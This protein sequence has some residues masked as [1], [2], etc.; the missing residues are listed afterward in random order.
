MADVEVIVKYS[1]DLKEVEQALSAKTEYL[2]DDYAIMTLP[3]N[4]AIKLT[5]YIQIEYVE[6]P[7]QLNS[8]SNTVITQ[9][10]NLPASSQTALS[11]SCITSVQGGTRFNLTGKYILV[12][13]LDSGIDYTHPDFLGSNGKTR[14]AY[15]WDQT[16]KPPENGTG[17]PPPGFLYG[18]EYNADQINLAIETLKEGGNPYSI[19]NER[20]ELGHGTGVAGVAAGLV[21]V[22]PEATLLVVKLGERESE[23]NP[24][25]TQIM[26]GVKYS[27]DKA[28]ELGLPLVINLSYGTNDGG[29]DGKSLFETYINEQCQKWRTSFVVATGNEGTAGHHYSGTVATN[30]RVDVE[31][32]TQK[33]I[34][35]F[36]MTLWKSFIDSFGLE[37]I[38]PSGI[39]T[40]RINQFESIRTYTLEDARIFVYY[41]EATHYN[42][43]QEVFF[44]FMPRDSNIPG[45]T[46]GIA[47]GVWNLRITGE[48]IT[49]GRFDIWLPIS[50]LVSP[51]TAF[52]KPES[53]TTLTIPSTAENVIS[54]GGYNSVIGNISSF[55]GQGFTRNGVFVKPN[56]VAPAENIIAPKPGGGYDSYTGTSIAAPF[57]SGSAALLMQWGIVYS[58]DPY[59][60]GQRLKAFLQNG[61]I[62]TQGTIYP[63]PQSGY[64]KLCLKS[65]LDYLNLY[66]NKSTVAGSFGLQPLDAQRTAITSDEVSRPSLNEY[67][68]EYGRAIPMGLMDL[69]SLES[70]GILYL[71]ETP[72][73]QLRGKG[74]ILGFA[75][76]G[77]DYTQPE[78]IYEDGTSKILFLWDQSTDTVYTNEDISRA[79]ASDDPYE[80]VPSRDTSGHGTFLASVAGARK[81]KQLVGAAPD[82]DMIVVKLK[83]ASKEL[84][85]NFV[86][87]PS[88]EDVFDSRDLCAAVKFMYDQATALGKP[89][90]ICIGIGTSFT[91]HDGEADFEKFIAGISQQ[92][93]VIISVA[94]GNEGNAKHHHKSRILKSGLSAKI[95]LRVGEREYGFT[96]LLCH[97]RTDH[98]SVMIVAPSGERVNR[99]SPLDSDFTGNFLFQKGELTIDYDDTYI[100]LR[101]KEPAEGIWS[102]ILNGD[103]IRNG[104][105]H[106]YLPVRSLM[107]PQTVNE[108]VFL[109][110]D[111]DYTITAPASTPYLNSAG[112]YSAYDDRL[113]VETSRG[114][115]TLYDDL[116]LLVAPGVMVGGLYPSGYGTMT[117]SSVSAA[118]LA[119]GSALLLEW[120]IVRGNKPTLNTQIAAEALA[121]GANRRQNL[122][123]PDNRW[124]YGELNMVNALRYLNSSTGTPTVI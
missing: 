78:F 6:F 99:I 62:R 87:S 51:K 2:S 82:A 73:L 67:P 72:V 102:I 64:G 107:S 22:A 118:T 12:A 106:A 35:T 11:T 84:Y 71:Q 25:T 5:R 92:N 54:V 19:V 91:S 58:N 16:G 86:I 59:L 80:I 49:I 108:T 39:S 37:I 56:I 15:I 68:I 121:K 116:P 46:P 42:L 34:G 94:A 69:R 31:F 112:C 97:D 17:G 26:R 117:G 124:G 98:L 36:Y 63:N 10:T 104:F 45:V 89:I 7:K 123:Y 114:P 3:E 85:D 1:G 9:A 33:G 100:T 79:I 95:D 113:Y 81:A 83:K 40:G 70:T 52:L 88:I 55:S 74:V 38:S 119:G 77:I 24:K 76:T 65:T 115:N 43:D 23:Q 20:D 44:R 66:A 93:G 61:A 75:D 48:N 101:F 110:P 60:Y 50:E 18:I 13:I 28:L 109:M 57:V 41:G 32:T 111:P 47:E 103:E 90:S 27:L 122:D 8:V 105:F 30:E 29:H 4:N 53:R 96:V 120:G 14:I 21:G